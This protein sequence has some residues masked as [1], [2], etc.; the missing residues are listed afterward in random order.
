LL[1]YAQLDT[2]LAMNLIQQIRDSFN[3][4]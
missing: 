2:E 1:V 3:R 4:T